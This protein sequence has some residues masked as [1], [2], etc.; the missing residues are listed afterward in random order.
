MGLGR[1]P[2]HSPYLL[3]VLSQLVVLARM[4]TMALTAIVNCFASHSEWSV[5]TRY[6]LLCTMNITSRLNPMNFSF[7]ICNLGTI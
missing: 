5:P 4:T 7:L 2:G 3:G 1:N 6:Q